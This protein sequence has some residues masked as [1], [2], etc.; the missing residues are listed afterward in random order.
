MTEKFQDFRV[1]NQVETLEV[2][3]FFIFFI[4]LDILYYRG[5]GYPSNIIIK[6]LKIFIFVFFLIG[7]GIKSLENLLDFVKKN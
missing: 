7:G 3:K 1:I 4:K 5:G 2:F 6:Y